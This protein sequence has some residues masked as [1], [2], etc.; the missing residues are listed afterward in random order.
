MTYAQIRILALALD[1]CVVG[2]SLILLGTMGMRFRNSAWRLWL[3]V[4]WM[5]SA[6]AMCVRSVFHFAKLGTPGI[7]AD[8]VFLTVVLVAIWYRTIHR[9]W[10]GWWTGW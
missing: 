1:G 8:A 9:G 3:K 4:A 2:I 10:A 5:V 7:V 6:I